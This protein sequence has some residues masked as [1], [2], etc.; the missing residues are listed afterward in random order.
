MIIY[1]IEGLAVLITIYSLVL[2]TAKNKYGWAI[3][4]V[5]NFLWAAI[6]IMRKIW[7]LIIISTIYFIFN[8]RAF[9]VWNKEEKHGGR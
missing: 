9:Y 7:S 4:I 1:I 3:S 2:L 8:L 5:L 6:G